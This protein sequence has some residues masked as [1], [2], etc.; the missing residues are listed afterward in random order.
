EE[1]TFTAEEISSMVL[2]KMREIAEAYL[3]TTIK[4]VVVTIHAHF[5]DSQRQATKDAGAIAGLNVMRVM[6]EPK[7]TAM[8]YGL[9]N[10]MTF[11]GENVLIF[12]LG[13][14]TCDVSLLNMDKG[15]FEVKATAGDTYLGG[16]DFDNRIDDN[17]KMEDSTIHDVVL[18]GNISVIDGHLGVKGDAPPCGV[19]GQRPLRGQ[20]AEPLAA[21]I[22]TNPTNILQSELYTILAMAEE[23]VFL[24]DNVEGGLCVDYTDVEIVGRCNSGSDK[25]KGKVGE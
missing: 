4:D 12:D 6:N 25:D 20:G 13:G 16:E 21:R 18:V 2:I 7:A 5:N 9:D 24:V 22:I 8:A 11:K 14:G 23:D 10:S 19:K 17:L 15:V 1:K 3:Q